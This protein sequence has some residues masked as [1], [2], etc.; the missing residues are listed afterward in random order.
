MLVW[1]CIILQNQTV[2][3]KSC[4]LPVYNPQTKIFGNSPSLNSFI[5]KLHI[6]QTYDLAIFLQIFYT[7]KNIFW[8]GYTAKLLWDIWQG[9]GWGEGVY[10]LAPATQIVGSLLRNPWLAKL[11]WKFAKLCINIIQFGNFFPTTKTMFVILLFG[12]NCQ[13]VFV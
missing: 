4:Q 11:A 7:C 1:N 9:G 12:N 2:S 5:A 10:R 3:F 6:I 8:F 13:T